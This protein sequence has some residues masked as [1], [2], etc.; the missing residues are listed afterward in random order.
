MEGVEVG[1]I[2][3]IAQGTEAVALQILK[4]ESRELEITTSLL[5]IVHN[6]VEVGSIVVSRHQKEI[7]ERYVDLVLCLL[8]PNYTLSWKKRALEANLPL[9]LVIA[10]SCPPVD[11]S[12]SQRIATT[13]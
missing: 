13:S 5:N 7:Y 8:S 3:N 12:S 9:V 1:A 6:V 2:R 10:N 11:V 4:S